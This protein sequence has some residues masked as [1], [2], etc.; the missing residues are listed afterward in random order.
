MAMK[1][2]LKGVVGAEPVTRM[3]QD[4][5]E[6]TT[7]SVAWKPMKDAQTIWVSVAC[8]T[9]CSNTAKRCKPKD[10]V[11]VTGT[12]V[13]KAGDGGKVFYN[14]NYTDS[15]EILAPWEDSQE[16]PRATTSNGRVAKPAPKAPEAVEY[17]FLAE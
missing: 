15:V 16:T 12:L 6:F 13:P 8:G 10:R 5:K 7:L 4:G 11:I 2:T 14:I 9:Y 17:D 3:G 1:V